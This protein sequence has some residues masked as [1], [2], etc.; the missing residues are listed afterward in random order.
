MLL[1]WSWIGF[2]LFTEALTCSHTASK[3]T[4]QQPKWKRWVSVLHFIHWRQR[5]SNAAVD[6][7]LKLSVE[8]WQALQLTDKFYERFRG[9]LLYIKVYVWSV[10]VSVCLK[11]WKIF[12]AQA[13]YIYNFL[14]LVFIHIHRGEGKKKLNTFVM[15][16]LY[17]AF[18]NK[19]N[20][21]QTHLKYSPILTSF[22]NDRA[23]WKPTTA[24]H[25]QNITHL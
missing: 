13:S 9:S 24:F 7:S 10:H 4:Q 23:K 5:F 20:V 3:G 14:Y 12:V 21:I 25:R 15:W 11:E 19:T 18:L 16:S 6:R 22:Y 1:S 17:R 2:D 8:A